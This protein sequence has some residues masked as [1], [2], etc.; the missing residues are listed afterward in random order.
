[1]L[2][3]ISDMQWVMSPGAAMYEDRFRMTPPDEKEEPL[4]AE[5]FGP[6]VEAS[7]F[8]AG[9]EWTRDLDAEELRDAYA[10]FANA[11]TATGDVMPDYDELQGEIARLEQPAQMVEKFAG[12]ASWN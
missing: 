4:S 7:V 3:P 1:M 10:L 12:R 5:N 11:V 2:H 9:L 8:G 6:I